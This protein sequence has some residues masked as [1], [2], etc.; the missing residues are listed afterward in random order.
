MKVSS[1]D[2]NKIKFAIVDPEADVLV[3]DRFRPLKI[4]GTQA[5]P[6]MAQSPEGI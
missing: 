4:V 1:R 5:R 3:A 2:V 6:L